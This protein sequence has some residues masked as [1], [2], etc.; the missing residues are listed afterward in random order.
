MSP[1]NDKPGVT[2]DRGV[3]SIYGKLTA[4]TIGTVERELSHY[5]PDDIKVTAN[6]K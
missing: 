2:F 6:R 3:I 5:F 4:S 1:E